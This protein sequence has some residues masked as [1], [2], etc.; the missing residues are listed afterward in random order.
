MLN[1][2]KFRTEINAVTSEY[3]SY[4]NSGNNEYDILLE[5]ANQEHGIAYTITGHCGNNKTLGVHTDEQL[6]YYLKNYFLTI[7]KPENCVFLIYSSRS[8]NEMRDYALKYYDFTLEEPE[9]EFKEEFNK[10]NKTLDY[11]LFNEGQLGKI[12][13]FN[14]LRETPVLSIIFPISQKTKYVE[15]AHIIILFIQWLW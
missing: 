9:K 5:N 14:S 4:N 2:T 10:K 3:D 11:P 8:L 6:R 12:A 7:F 13:T 1:S 15:A